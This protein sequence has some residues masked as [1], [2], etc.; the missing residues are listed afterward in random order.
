MVVS[1]RYA[2]EASC[3]QISRSDTFVL[4]YTR[5]TNVW[6]C[7]NYSSFRSVLHR[8]L[9]ATVFDKLPPNH[10]TPN[11]TFFTVAATIAVWQ[12]CFESK[13]VVRGFAW[14]MLYS[15]RVLALCYS[16]YTIF[17]FCRGLY[18]GASSDIRTT[19]PALFTKPSS[20]PGERLNQGSPPSLP[21]AKPPSRATVRPPLTVADFAA[22]AVA[23]SQIYSFSCDAHRPVSALPERGGTGPS[24]AKP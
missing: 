11:A 10:E 12:P 13:Q 8:L 19:F 23:A 22:A 5:S 14:T 17:R 7:R 21:G 15:L 4:L 20:R 9:A 18:S 16:V 6:I 24:P 2:H 1:Q 3:Q